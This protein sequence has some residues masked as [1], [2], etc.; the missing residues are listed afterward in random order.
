MIE[1]PDPYLAVVILAFRDDT[2]TIRYNYESWQPASGHETN[3]ITSQGECDKRAGGACEW[4]YF[5][6]QA[7]QA[8]GAIEQSVERVWARIELTRKGLGPSDAP[9]P[10]RDQNLVCRP[11]R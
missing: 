11:T 9:E 1:Q 3:R 5:V 7:S 8:R 10:V 6:V 4:E 2:T